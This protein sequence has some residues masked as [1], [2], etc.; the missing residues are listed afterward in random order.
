MFASL[1]A[2]MPVI[3]RRNFPTLMSAEMFAQSASPEHVFVTRL[4]GSGSTTTPVAMSEQ[5]FAWTAQT[6]S[7]PFTGSRHSVVERHPAQCSSL[8]QAVFPGRKRPHGFLHTP[9]A[10]SHCS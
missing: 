7:P 2:L 10:R 4:H 1:I 5:P 8:R 3:C 6:P 9:F